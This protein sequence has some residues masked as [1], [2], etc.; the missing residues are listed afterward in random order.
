MLVLTRRS[1]ESVVVGDPA[2]RSYQRLKIIVLEISGDRVRLGF[3]GADDVPIHRSEVWQRIHSQ[4]VPLGGRTD[5]R[6]LQA[7]GGNT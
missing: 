1:R 6:H 7:A 2:G 4:A 5:T 3:E